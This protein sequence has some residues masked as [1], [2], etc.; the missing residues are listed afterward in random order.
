MSECFGPVS[1]AVAVDSAADAVELLRR[2]I[3]DKGAMTVGAYTTDPEFERPS[4]RPA[5]RSAPSCR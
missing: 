5:W 4:R 3:R 1:F 2:T